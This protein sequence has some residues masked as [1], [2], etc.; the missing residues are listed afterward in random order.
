MRFQV[1]ALLF[2]ALASLGV[3]AHEPRP[4]IAQCANPVAISQH[5][6]T[7]SAIRMLIKNRVGINTQALTFSKYDTFT[8]I[9]RS[10]TR[11]PGNCDVTNTPKTCGFIDGD[12]RLDHGAWSKAYEAA[13]T[14]CSDLF[15]NDKPRVTAWP[16]ITAPASFLNNYED[17]DG[18]QMHHTLYELSEGVMFQCLY[19]TDEIP[20]IKE[21]IKP[22]DQHIES[23]RR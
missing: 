9:P 20:R 3:S 8:G 12:F 15:I 14:V 4:A 10:P 19:C 7:A 11:K 22:K 18:K 6:L 13:L 17:E 23:M 2:G 1:L 21:F 16:E 5:T